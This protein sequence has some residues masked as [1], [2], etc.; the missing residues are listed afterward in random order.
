MSAIGDETVREDEGI[1]DG[2]LEI[3]GAFPETLCLSPIET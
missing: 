2:I 1:V 3:S